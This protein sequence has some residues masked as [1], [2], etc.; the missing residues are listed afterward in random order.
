M[1]TEKKTYYSKKIKNNISFWENKKNS[2]YQNINLRNFLIK[3]V[4]K[5]KSHF[6]AQIHKNFKSI[7]RLPRNEKMGNIYIESIRDKD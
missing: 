6:L 5:T 4:N 7:M 2:K 3:K 1:Y